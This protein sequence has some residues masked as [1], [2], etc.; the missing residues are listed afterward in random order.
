M[1]TISVSARTLLDRF[2][3]VPAVGDDGPD[4]QVSKRSPEERRDIRGL[5]FQQLSRMSL[6]ACG[7][8]LFQH[9][10]E[11]CWKR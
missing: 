6:R 2:G 7:Y 9:Y 1:A 5:S 3:F 11:R 8:L 10:Y 4:A